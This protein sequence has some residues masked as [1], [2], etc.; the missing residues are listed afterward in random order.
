MVLRAQRKPDNPSR[1]IEV[2][3]ASACEICAWW[4]NNLSI[5]YYLNNPLH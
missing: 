5:V 1:P 3:S 2:L 4:D